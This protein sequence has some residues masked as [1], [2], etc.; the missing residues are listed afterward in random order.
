MDHYWI[1]RWHFF[2]FYATLLYTIFL[3]SYSITIASC[4]SNNSWNKLC[5]SIN[6]IRSFFFYV[7]SYVYIP[8]LSVFILSIRSYL[9]QFQI[10]LFFFS[11]VLWRSF[12]H[13]AIFHFTNESILLTWLRCWGSFSLIIFIFSSHDVVY[14]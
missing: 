3:L 1:C 7:H 14:I 2:S 11:F 5:V 9:R 8:F 12:R 13:S 4:C 6:Q 10:Q